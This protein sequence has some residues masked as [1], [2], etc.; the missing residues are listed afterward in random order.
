MSLRAIPKARAGQKLP[1]GLA[2]AAP[3]LDNLEILDSFKNEYTTVEKL[4]L[5]LNS[6]FVLHILQSNLCTKG[7]LGTQKNGRCLKGSHYL[8]FILIKLG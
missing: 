5:N 6:K 2:L 1:E 3:G 4:Q 8:Q 7:I